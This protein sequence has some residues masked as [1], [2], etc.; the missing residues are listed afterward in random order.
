[1]VITTTR[2]REMCDFCD[3]YSNGNQSI[4][5]DSEISYFRYP[6]LSQKEKDMPTYQ[7]LE[8]YDY[9]SD[10]GFLKYFPN[11]RYKP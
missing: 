5:K 2:K 1:M 10:L 7:P 11:K 9:G 3:N 6:P 8:K 4:F